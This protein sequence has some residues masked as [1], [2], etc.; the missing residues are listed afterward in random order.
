MHDKSFHDELTFDRLVDGELSAGERRELLASLDDRP[1]GWRRCALAFLEAQSWTEDLGQ[2]VREPVGAAIVGSDAHGDLSRRPS[3]SASMRHGVP[4]LAV[5]AGLLLAFT[6]GLLWPGAGTPIAE[7]IA[8]DPNGQ[9]A[10]VAPAP[11][12]LDAERRDDTLTLWVRDEGGGA[13][14][15]RVPLVDAGALDRQLGLQFQT[16]VPEGVR[17][18]LQDRGFDVQSKR[19]YAPLWLENGRPMIVPV[20]DTRIVPVSQVW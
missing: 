6:I 18:R 20:E 7:N 14:P 5:A 10:E 2:F 4:W 19:R 16:G 9:V 13:R 12:P 15:I 1:D 8:Q 11:A 17:R 3:G